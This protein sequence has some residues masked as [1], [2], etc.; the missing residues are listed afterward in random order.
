[1]LSLE[2]DDVM[3]MHFR[4]AIQCIFLANAT[5]LACLIFA[6]I[7]KLNSLSPFR[8][9]VE[10]LALWRYAALPKWQFRS[11]LLLF[12]DSPI[13]TQ[14]ICSTIYVCLNH[15]SLTGR[16]RRCAAALHAITQ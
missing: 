15:S 4:P 5:S 10:S 8:R 11:A 9:R 3:N 13:E 2:P 7:N 12:P 6:A 14:S 16:C 1:M